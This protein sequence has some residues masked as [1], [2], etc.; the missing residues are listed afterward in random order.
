M[1]HTKTIIIADNNEMHRTVCSALLKNIDEH[2]QIIE[3]YYDE[4]LL[5]V[6]KKHKDIS[7]LFV[8]ILSSGV[9]NGEIFRDIA[10]AYPSVPKCIM[11]GF[12]ESLELVDLSDISYHVLKKPASQQQ[13]AHIIEQMGNR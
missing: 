1:K 12:V 10:A 13:L 5:D 9:I 7:L 4:T 11:T 3:H 8:D 2:I 6:I